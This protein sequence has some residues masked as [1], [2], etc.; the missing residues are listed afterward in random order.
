MKHAESGVVGMAMQQLVAQSSFFVHFGLHASLFVESYVVQ[1]KPSQ[2]S[3][4]PPHVSSA[5]AHWQS[6]A[7]AQKPLSGMFANGMQQPLAQSA[8]VLHGS[9]QPA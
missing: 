9:R 5:P 1:V 2:H 4:A 8:A 3:R 7:S 6:K